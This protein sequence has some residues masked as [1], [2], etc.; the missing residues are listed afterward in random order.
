MTPGSDCWEAG[1]HKASSKDRHVL[2]YPLCFPGWIACTH[3]PHQRAIAT[4]TGYPIRKGFHQLCRCRA[5]RRPKSAK[6][7]ALPQHRAGFSS[8]CN[9]NATVN[10]M[11]QTILPKSCTLSKVIGWCHTSKPHRYIAVTHYT[12]NNVSATQLT[13]SPTCENGIYETM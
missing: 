7:G 4:W 3:K 5:I 1:T 2:F 10:S 11:F 8:T 9:H 6:E 13:R 12:S